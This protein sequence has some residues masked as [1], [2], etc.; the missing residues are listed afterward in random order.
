MNELDCHICEGVGLPKLPESSMRICVVCR[1]A[2]KDIPRAQ[3]KALIE[4]H[5]H[6]MFHRLPY[7]AQYLVSDNRMHPETNVVAKSA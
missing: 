4:N 3:R 1:D 2:L 5:D 7:F 6:Y